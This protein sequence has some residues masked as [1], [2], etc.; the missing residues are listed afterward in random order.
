MKRHVDWGASL[1]A[2][3]PDQAAIAK[4]R[5]ETS[6]RS[7]CVLRIAAAHSYWRAGRRGDPEHHC[8]ARECRVLAGRLPVEALAGH[9]KL[10]SERIAFFLATRIPQAERPEADRLGASHA[11]RMLIFSPG[12]GELG[13]R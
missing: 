7:A 12:C 5:R 2:V 3:L 6:P 4:A 13:I 1:P 11:D 8:P 9:A 10:K